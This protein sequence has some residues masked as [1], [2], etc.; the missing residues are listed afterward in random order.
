VRQPGPGRER[1]ANQALPDQRASSA[2]TQSQAPRNP[3]LPGLPERLRDTVAGPTRQRLPSIPRRHRTS[4]CRGFTPRNPRHDPTERPTSQHRPL[5]PQR[6]STSPGTPTGKTTT[7][8][9][10]ATRSVLPQHVPVL[11]DRW[12]GAAYCAISAETSASGGCLPI[13]APA[14]EVHQTT[15]DRLEP[16]EQ[17]TRPGQLLEQSETQLA[18]T[19]TRVDVRRTTWRLIAAPTSATRPPRRVPPLA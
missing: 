14:G 15:L 5:S 19:E 17:L 8:R 13:E 4:P 12:V 10:S 9:R 1:R 11:A 3:M 6:P 16:G 2:P 18:D 7:S